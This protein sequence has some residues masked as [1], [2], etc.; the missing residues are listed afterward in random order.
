MTPHLKLAIVLFVIAQGFIIGAG[1]VLFAIIG[2]VNR[3]LPPE[4]HISY[5]LGYPMKYIRVTREYRRLYP[6][7]FLHIWFRISLVIGLGLLGA[8]AWAI[9]VLW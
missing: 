5:L 6:D 2:E 4:Q 7:G 3:R 9:G 8:F 1:F